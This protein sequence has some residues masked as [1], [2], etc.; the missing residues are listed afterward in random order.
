MANERSFEPDLEDP[1]GVPSLSSS[2]RK[3]DTLAVHGSYDHAA[4][5]ANQGSLIEPLYLTTAQHFPDSAT[6]AAVLGY[7]QPGWGYSRIANPTVTELESRLALLETYGSDVQASACTAASGMAAV[8]L[9]TTPLL[10]ARG[11]A[12]VVASA[13]CYGGTFMLFAERFGKERG[14]DVRWVSDPSDLNEWKRLIDGR[15][16]F[17]YVE[18][19]SNPTLV[20]ADVAALAELAHAAEV[21]LIVDSTLISPALFRPLTHGADIVIHSLTKVI[22]ANGLTVG[23]A[24]IARRPLTSRSLLEVERVDYATHV[25]RWPARDYGPALNPFAALMVLAELRTLRSRVNVFSQR[26]QRVAEFLVSHPAVDTVWYPGLRSFP[27]HV[28][29][30][31]QFALV[32]SET[33]TTPAQPRY[34]HLLGFTVSAGAATARKVL[35]RLMLIARATDLGRIKSV[36]TIP[37]ISTHQQQ[38]HAARQL[39]A[40]P[41]NLIRLSVG[42][43]HADDVIADLDRA[44]SIP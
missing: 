23:G 5:A 7:E 36:A 15:T 14:V 9:A 16:R 22:A 41:D 44:L 27:G 10:A 43:E 17:V 21:P 18:V 35:D 30:R 3:F 4:M 42:G 2:L 29:A 34:G 25:K 11:T 26:A 6:L 32:D 1:L 24:F 28:L 13:H 40:I 38:G 20:V 19:P 31:R 8:F 12:N 39:A 37:A 33:R